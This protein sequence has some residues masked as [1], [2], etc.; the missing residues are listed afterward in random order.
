[1]VKN[2][3]TI[4]SKIRDPVLQQTDPVL[5]S[6]MKLL[7]L[8]GLPKTAD[9]KCGKWPLV[10]QTERDDAE[11]TTGWEN[12]VAIKIMPELVQIERI[13]LSKWWDGVSYFGSKCKNRSA[14]CSNPSMLF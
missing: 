7:A 4:N 5:N 12:I 6:A 11:V 3:T 1:M 14:G 10:A 9:I 8:G 2:T 13:A